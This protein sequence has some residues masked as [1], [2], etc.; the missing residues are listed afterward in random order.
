L[1]LKCTFV[2]THHCSATVTADAACD[3]LLLPC[4]LSRF[5]EDAG[6]QRVPLL[7]A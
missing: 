2:V 4:L 6:N 1:V 7:A 5:V 3:A